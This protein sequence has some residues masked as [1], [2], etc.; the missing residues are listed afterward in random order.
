MSDETAAE[1]IV[2]PIP[3]PEIKVIGPGKCEVRVIGGYDDTGRSPSEPLGG[4]VVSKWYKITATA[5][6]GSSLV[7]IKLTLEESVKGKKK[8]FE[9]TI[10]DN[11]YRTAWFSPQEYETQYYWKDDSEGD[12]WDSD[13]TY[14]IASIDGNLVNFVITDEG[15]YWN[16]KATYITKIRIVA[17]FSIKGGLLY[18]EATNYLLYHSDNHL[19]CGDE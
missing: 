11:I 15:D 13:H 7:G 16:Q 3:E 10:T 17:T 8:I 4:D 12:G 6:K 1:P 9:K 2:L 5:D 18:D 19:I 14:Y